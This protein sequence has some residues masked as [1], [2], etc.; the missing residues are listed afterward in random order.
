MARVIGAI[1]DKWLALGGERSF[2]GQPVTDELK[3]VDGVGRFNRFQGGVI[4]FLSE[5]GAHEVHGNIL[6]KWQSLSFV[7]S[8]LGFPITDEIAFSEGGRASIFQHG[9]IYFWNDTGPIELKQV[10]A[11]F[12]GLHAF[13]IT[14]GPGL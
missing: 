12:T 10:V 4:F 3:T 2:L 6:D 7:R 14:D 9:G 11:R 1:R 5:N 13:G 8:F